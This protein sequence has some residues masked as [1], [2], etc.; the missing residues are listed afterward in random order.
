MHSSSGHSRYTVTRMTRQI[1]VEVAFAEPQRQSLVC[2]Q[3]EAGATVAEAIERSGIAARHA[4]IA[5]DSL[6]AGI[7]GRLVGRDAALS[8][9]DRVEIYRELCIEPREA[10]RQ[11]ALS[12]RTMREGDKEATT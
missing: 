2:V 8:D 3:L 12:G 4:D 9:G 6:P 7:W 11:L 5:I 10:R 1:S